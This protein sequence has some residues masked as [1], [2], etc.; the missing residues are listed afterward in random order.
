MGKRRHSKRKQRQ[1]WW[2]AILTFAVFCML[3]WESDREKKKPVEESVKLLHSFSGESREE[4]EKTQKKYRDREIRV[5]IKTDG[6]ASLF[7][8]QV[9]F[10]S[11]G[12]YTVSVDGKQ[13]LCKKGEKI[14]FRSGGQWKGKKI[15]ITPASER[16]L[17]ILSVARQSRHP[18]YRGRIQLTWKKK[19][20]L[21]CNRLSLEQYLY[22]VVPSELSTRSEMEALKAQAVCAR[23]YACNQMKSKR[24]D[25]YQAD[26]DDSVAFQVYNNIPEDARSRKAVD[27]TEG[28]VLS[29]KNQLVQA[30]Y[31]ST[32]WGYTADGKDVW[33]TEGDIAYLKSRFQITPESRK[34]TGKKAQS[35]SEEKAF[36]NFLRHPG[37]ETYDSGAQ[38]YRWSVSIERQSLS[39]RIDGLL[40]ACYSEN[41]DLVLTQTADG[42]Y[43]RKALRP[44]GT[45]KKIRVERRE[46]SGLV[47]EIVLVGTG[48]VV[49]V[50][51][52]Y[53]IRRVLAPLYERVSC[54]GG[55]QKS[56]VQLL[57]SAAFS[58]GVL[59]E[60][61]QTSF[62][63]TGGGMGHG[64]GMSQCG[65]ARMAKLGSDYRE[66]LDHYFAGTELASLSALEG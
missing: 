36:L 57:P 38:W 30:Y 58:I 59:T 46:D 56:R 66:I 60:G 52:Q 15:V 13:T 42:G 22:A 18:R 25:K 64:A 3:L 17:Q 43:Q 12:P 5:L 26:V 65:A 50:M 49:K 51:T 32:S 2:I 27:S 39:S 10:T 47:T 63:I 28:I 24:Y 35:L 6:F 33:N 31:Y 16:R 20:F 19:G 54:G 41:P 7:H 21:V 29:R 34:K 1:L 4:E 45:V 62:V 37:C 23:S 44:M 14:S 40:S 48:N 61:K 8:R 11:D 9:D 55:K 53:N